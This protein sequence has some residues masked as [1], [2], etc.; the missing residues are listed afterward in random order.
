MVWPARVLVIGLLLACGATAGEEAVPVRRHVLALVAGAGP[1]EHNNEDIVHT[2]V[3][4]PINHLGFVVDRHYIDNGPPPAAALDRARAVLLY[5]DGGKPAKWL[6]PWLEETV[7]K[8]D[9]RVVHFSGFGPLATD[10]PRLAR[11]LARFGLAYD[12]GFVGD[13]LGIN[14]KMLA[15]KACRYEADPR[16]FAE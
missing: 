7:A 9:V 15:G 11:W 4:L 8:R 10:T 14:T 13:P 16:R 5:L 2:L 6:W 3:E 12:A 1:D